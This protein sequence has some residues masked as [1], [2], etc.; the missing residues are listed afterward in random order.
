[1]RAA[2]PELAFG[3]WWQWWQSN[4]R[5]DGLV[6]VVL[7]VVL[8]E[9]SNIILLLQL[10]SVVKFIDIEQVKYHVVVNSKKL[11]L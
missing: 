9:H 3:R 2:H 8:I 11:K 7:V 10:F 6:V 1:M 5:R 4:F